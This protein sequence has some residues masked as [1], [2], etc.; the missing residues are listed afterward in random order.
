MLHGSTVVRVAWY[1]G[2]WVPA[3]S[4]ALSFARR[5]KL[6]LRWNRLPVAV[7][8]TG[9][10]RALAARKTSSGFQ[11]PWSDQS[12]NLQRLLLSAP[13]WLCRNYQ[14]AA[15]DRDLHPVPAGSVILSAGRITCVGCRHRYGGS[16]TLFPLE[17]RSS[18]DRA[19]T[20]LN[21]GDP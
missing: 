10:Q 11:A 15:R 16:G 8:Y 3:K 19:A 20:T 7:I 17:L 12:D 13:P 4:T 21:L 18:R 14:P 5:P 1:P 2:P 6:P 9:G